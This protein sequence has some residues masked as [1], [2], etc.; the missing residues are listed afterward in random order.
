MRVGLV[1][2][3]SLD[4]LSGGFLYDRMLVRYLEAQGDKVTVLSQPWESYA[5]CLAHNLS[6]PFAERL[7]QAE[8]DVLLQDELNHPSL[9]W[10]N[11]RLRN[12]LRYP[13][14]SIVHH[15]RVSE[16]RPAWQNWLYGRVERAYLRTLDGLICNSRTTR[17]SVAALAGGSTPAVVAWPAAD[18]RQP[19]V[20]PE[21]LAARVGRGEALRVLFIGN[22]IP[23][24]GL[25]TLLRAIAGLPGV[26]LDVVGKTDVDADYTALIEREIERL[27]LV[28]RVRLLGAQVD[29]ELAV[30]LSH[31]DVL[32]V[33]SQYEGFGIVYLEGMG[34]GLPVIASSGGAARELVEPGVNGWLVTPGDDTAIAGY[35]RALQDDRDL[36]YAMSMAA[37]AT[38]YRHPTWE[39]SMA[40]AR[41]YLVR[42]VD[43]WQRD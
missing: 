33:P 34:F 12:S 13:I 8:F 23:R 7:L 27:G 40:R 42:L 35:L 25:D 28:E 9:F 32:A 4:T 26:E 18:H 5:R 10:L 16:Q 11:R 15:L 43:G 31:S 37:L 17:A 41:D 39:D 24:K 20:M 29:G 3:G 30:R 6:R 1:I 38:Y 19:M 2:Y 22:L 36:L 14:V 21:V